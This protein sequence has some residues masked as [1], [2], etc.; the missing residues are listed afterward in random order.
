MI[1]RINAPMALWGYT[2]QTMEVS[3]TLHV[4]ADLPRFDA[5]H[6]TKQGLFCQGSLHS[7]RRSLASNRTCSWRFLGAGLGV[8]VAQQP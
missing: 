7:N 6:L 8:K 1:L 2:R 4:G 3:F 5:L